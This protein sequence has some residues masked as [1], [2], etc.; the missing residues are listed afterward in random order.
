MAAADNSATAPAAPKPVLMAPGTRDPSANHAMD[1]TYSLAMV[2]VLVVATL[3]LWFRA[4]FCFR[5][6]DGA[7]PCRPMPTVTVVGLPP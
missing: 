1:K 7:W 2:A 5:K 4:T 3:F 6:V